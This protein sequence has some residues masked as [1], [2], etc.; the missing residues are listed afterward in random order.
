MQQKHP[1]II[2]SKSSALNLQGRVTLIMFLG[3]LLMGLVMTLR[4]VMP[5]V[6]SVTMGGVLALLSYPVYLKLRRRHFNSKSASL[7]VTLGI[8]FL[9]IAPVI[10]F[11]TITVKQAMS[12]INELDSTGVFSFKFL[13][14]RISHWELVNRV[15]GDPE[16]L[17]KQIRDWIQGI[18]KFGTSALLSW[19]GNVPKIV[20]QLALASISCFFFLM[21]GPKFLS[22]ISDKIPMDS[23]V[24]A[25][26]YQ[27]F[28]DTAISSIWAT[29]AAALAQSVIM[30]ISFV[31]LGVPAAFLATGAT[32]IFAWIPILGS[33]PVWLSGA[34][35]L[36]LKS[37]ILKAVL[38]IILGC[39]TGVVDNFV[40]PIVLKGRGNLHPL[41]G[42]VAIFGGI[43]MF[44]LIGIFIGP[45]L[46]AVVLSILQIWP[47][48]GQ[49]FGLMSR[50]S[51]E[52][53]K[54]K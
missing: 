29:L 54:I 34:L 15:V 44:G 51:G 48:V 22:W 35:Y 12:L 6:L 7:I 17:D 4:M 18:G 40:R 37:S 10:T 26:I 14:N 13:L 27:S 31:S 28:Q 25:K 30:L 42:L 36:Y 38:M 50:S 49:R 9:V 24:R 19:A 52:V 47:V 11:F 32:F 46:V 45:I 20:L 23:D 43:E 53:R 8:I 5:Y 2:E 16:T 1:K 33:T 39:I 21:D 41:I 3:L